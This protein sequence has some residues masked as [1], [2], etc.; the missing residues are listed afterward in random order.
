MEL[1]LSENV[2]KFNLAFLLLILPWI[3]MLLGLALH[4]ENGWF[5]L[6]CILWFGAGIVFFGALE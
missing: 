6:L 4:F 3:I 5:F 2:R 1:N